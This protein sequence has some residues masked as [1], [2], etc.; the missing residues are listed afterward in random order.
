MKGTLKLDPK[1]SVVPDAEDE[2]E[3][4]EDGEDN[5]QQSEE[6]DDD[7]DEKVCDDEGDD[8]EDVEDVDDNS[9]EFIQHKPSRKSASKSGDAKPMLSSLV[10]NTTPLPASIASRYIVPPNPQWHTITLPKLSPGTKVLSSAD[11][12]KI[13]AR[14]STLFE[15]DT[16]AHAKHKRMSHSD[17]AFVSTVLKSGTVTDKVSALTLLI[18]DSPLHSLPF[19]RTNLLNNMARIKTRRETLLAVDAIVDFFV[20]TILPDRKINR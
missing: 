5:E 14:A 6:E 4:D 15:T 12:S 10:G 9:D 20:G 3:D 17:R 8:E 16:A 1:R 19:L 18:Q 13:Y 7:E 2:P 11:V